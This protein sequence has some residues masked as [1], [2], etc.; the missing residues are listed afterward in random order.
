MNKKTQTEIVQNYLNSINNKPTHYT[1]ISEE[2]GIIVHN[3]RRICGEGFHNNIFVRHEKG[4]YSNDTKTHQFL[5]EDTSRR[6]FIFDTGVT[7][8]DI[9]FEQYSWERSRYNKVREGDFFIY[10]RPTKVSENRK[11][12]FFGMGQM[13]PIEGDGDRVIGKVVNPIKFTNIIYQDDITNYEWKWKEKT[14]NDFQYF[15]N[16]YGM[17]IIPFKDFEYFCQRGIDNINE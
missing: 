11:F 10:R 17:N 3:V 13:G 5:T 2:T 14:R 15:F 8:D 9:D 12:Y 7:H 6:Y 16:I 1:K 4:V